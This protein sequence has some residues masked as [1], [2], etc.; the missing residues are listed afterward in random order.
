MTRITYYEMLL[1]SLA[2]LTCSSLQAA[3]LL[4][5]K[6]K[7]NNNNIVSVSLCVAEI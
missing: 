6:S 1:L 5:L 3:E 4:M 7:S 2:C